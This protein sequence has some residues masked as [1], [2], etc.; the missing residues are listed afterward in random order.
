MGCSRRGQQIFKGF[1]GFSSHETSGLGH[2]KNFSV[3]YTEVNISSLQKK[4]GF[5]PLW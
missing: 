5:W 3:L 2:G 1:H 4:R